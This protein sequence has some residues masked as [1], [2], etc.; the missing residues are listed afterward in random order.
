MLTNFGSLTPLMN[1]LLAGPATLDRMEFV[2]PAAQLARIQAATEQIANEAFKGVATPEY[3]E[4][5]E[6]VQTGFIRKAVQ[7]PPGAAV[8]SSTQ[9][10]TLCTMTPHYKIQDW[11]TARPLMQSIIDKANAEPGCAYFG[12]TKSGDELRS[13]ETF[14]SGDAMKAHIEGCK[15]F[16]EALVAE[17]VA[18]LERLEINA[19]TPELEKVKTL[20]ESLHAEKLEYFGADQKTPQVQHALKQGAFPPPPEG[21]LAPAEAK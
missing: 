20:A 11:G 15:P 2:G 16:L 3:F 7:P 21:V 18:K 1:Q 17:G 10:N 13:R 5:V 6:D 8:G 14:V 19:P 4:M 12:W 9:A